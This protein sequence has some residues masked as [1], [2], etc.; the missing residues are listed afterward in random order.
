MVMYLVVEIVLVHC[1]I[2]VGILRTNVASG[3]VHVSYGGSHSNIFDEI[4]SL[5]ERLMA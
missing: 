2:A 5:Y 4:L 3:D 1:R